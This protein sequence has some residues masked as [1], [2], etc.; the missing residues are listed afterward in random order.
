VEEEEEVEDEEPGLRMR[1]ESWSEE[2]DVEDCPEVREDVEDWPALDDCPATAELTVCET[3]GW[4]C[5]M[6]WE[7][8]E[9][10][11]NELEDVPEDWL[12]DPEERLE[13]PEKRLDD[14]DER[15]VEE[16]RPED[17]DDEKTDPPPTDPA[18]SAT[19]VPED[20]EEEEEETGL[21]LIDTNPGCSLLSSV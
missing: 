2:T 21:G 12:E 5:E 17:P 6:I 4:I 10:W 16:E 1:R 7:T 3:R 18:G 14:P 8:R 11:S 13:E 15:L 9:D 20:P 19:R